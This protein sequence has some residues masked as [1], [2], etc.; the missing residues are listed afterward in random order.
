MA[1]GASSLSDA[2]LIA[3]I[4]RTGTKGIDATKL[5][6]EIIKM[7]GRFDTNDNDSLIGLAN[8]S[9][10]E[11]MK[12]KGV[13]RVKAVQIQCICELARRIA[14][15]TAAVKLDFSSPETIAGYYMQDLR[16]LDKEHLILVLLDNKCC[17]IRD[18]IISVG[19]VNASLVNPREIF[20]EALKYGAS[21]IILLHNHPSGDETPSRNDILVTKRVA[22]AGEI[23]G[24]RPV[25]RRRRN[26]GR[27]G[28]Y[29]GSSRS[30]T[31]RRRKRRNR[32]LKAVFL[33]LVCIVLTGLV[34]FGAVKL[35]GKFAGSGKDKLRKDGIEKLNAGDPEGAIADLDAAL[36][37]AGNKS[38]KPS[39]FNADVLWYRAEAELLLKDYEAASHTYDLIA[40]QGGDK[41]SCLYMKAVCVE[42][43]GDKDSAVSYYREAL[44]QEKEGSRSA[45]FE[46]ALIAAGSACVNGQD[47]DTAKSLYEE[48]LNS[49]KTGEKLDSRIYNQLGLCQMAEE[50]YNTAADSF[51][52]GYNALISG[53]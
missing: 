16:G 30:D 6:E 37:K 18:C 25:N 46:E 50:D 41:I 39:G 33:W 40:E 49:G 22:E 14:K 45:G 5:A 1:L 24:N 43:L 2:Q 32:R 42:K 17:R 36:E 53:Y 28:H 38:N 52:K 51:D 15:K 20:M 47:F 29:R 35:V 4:L 12:I 23:M 44:G 26:T 8:L 3:A 27:T 7:C 48:A 13:G 10:P 21:S 11:L 19:T 31:L 9:I 34:I